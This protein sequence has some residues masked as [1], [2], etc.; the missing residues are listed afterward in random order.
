MNLSDKAPLGVT[1]RDDGAEVGVYSADARDIFVCV[2]DSKGE[3]EVSRTRLERDGEGLFRGFVPGLV[4]GARYGLR[5]DGAFDPARGLRFDVSKLLADPYAVELDRPYKLDH[6]MFEFGA[7]SGVSAPKCIARSLA[8]AEPGR[9]RVAWEDTVLYELNMRGFT[10]LREDIPEA[11]RGRFAALTEAPVL[12]HLTKLGVTSVELMPADVFVDER[13]LPPLGLTN[14]WGY[15]PVIFGAPDPRLAPDGWREVRAA[16]DA[17]HARGLE[18]LLDVVLN[19]NGES[20]EFGPT[21]SFRGLDNATYFRLADDRALYVND[22]GCGNCLALDRPPVV[23]MAV[24]ALRRWMIAGGIDGFRFD[25]ATALGRRALGFDPHAPLL[26]AI[27]ADPVLSRAKLIAEPWDMGPGGY[28]LGQFPPN[29]GEWNDRFRD[30]ARRFWRGDRGL[31][32]ELATRLAGS[33]DV[34]GGAPSPTKSVNFIVAHDGLTLADLVSY[35]SKHNDANG[36][37]NGDGTNENYSWN[38][39]VEGPSDDPR[40]NA[41]RKQDMRNLLALLLVSRGAPMLAMGSETGHGQRGNNTRMRRTIRSP[42]WTGA[43]PTQ[44]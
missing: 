12:D 19:H 3:S 33:S 40:V 36:E 41:A 17:L 1:L 21:L 9:Q 26:E 43:W 35:A 32:G 13:H 14:A 31:R 28:Q 44:A 30:S 6:A 10:R 42:G 11:A 5:A 8:A 23:A 38:H 15:N 20:D 22:M 25:L 39:G 18:V 24:A 29:W 7:D 16:T 2:Y 27:A 4:E 34:F 37:Q